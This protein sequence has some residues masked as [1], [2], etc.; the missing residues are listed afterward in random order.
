[1]SGRAALGRPS[2][3]ERHGCIACLPGFGRGLALVLGFGLWLGR[4]DLIV[5]I[6]EEDALTGGEQCSCP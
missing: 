2:Q 5:G 4:M 1:M 3:R 6:L